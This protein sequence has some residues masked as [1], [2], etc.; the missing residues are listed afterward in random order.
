[1]HPGSKIFD[2]HKCFGRW[3][4][5]RSLVNNGIEVYMQ[6]KSTFQLFYQLH[7]FTHIGL[8]IPAFA[9]GAPACGCYFFNDGIN[10]ALGSKNK[11]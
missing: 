7:E 5:K 8:K 2:D 1:M 10:A 3:L 4:S 9:R 6:A 11:P